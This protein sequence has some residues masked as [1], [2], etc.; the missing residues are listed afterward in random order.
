MKCVVD[1]IAEVLFLAFGLVGQGG[2]VPSAEWCI[3]M[4]QANLNAG[5]DAASD[6]KSYA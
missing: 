2:H 1:C 6:S 4:L 5:I 3:E